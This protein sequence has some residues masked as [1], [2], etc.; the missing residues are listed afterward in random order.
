MQDYF[1]KHFF[2]RVTEVTGVTP[3]IEPLEIK[4]L[5]D[6]KCVTQ[7]GYT[8]V[9][10]VTNPENVTPVT[11]CNPEESYRNLLKE[12]SNS[13]GLSGV[14]TPVTHVTYPKNEFDNDFTGNYLEKYQEL[15]A[16]AEYLGGL[17]REWAEV[18]AKI[19]LMSKPKKLEM[20]YWQIFLDDTGRFLDLFVHQAAKLGW[21]PE[22]IFCCHR[23]APNNRYDCMGLIFLLQGKEIIE[24]SESKVV[25]VNQN[26]QKLS[27]VKPGAK[28]KTVGEIKMI[29]ELE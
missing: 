19:Q 29:W 10:G 27:F 15:S 1:A 11:Q 24:I 2:G 16:I 8:G 3:S 26:G 22:D 14:V 5:N 7:A 18:F 23:E 6:Y 12:S 13:N 21:R 25:M 9:T 28:Y 4:V 20:R 17:N